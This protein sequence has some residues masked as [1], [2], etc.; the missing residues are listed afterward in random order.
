MLDTFKYMFLIVLVVMAMVASYYVV[1]V[2]VVAS[3]AYI[4]ARFIASFRKAWNESDRTG[5]H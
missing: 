2:L 4:L 3:I 1:I 5:N